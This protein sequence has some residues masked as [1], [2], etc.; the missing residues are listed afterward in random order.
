[1]L[2]EPVGPGT[3][4]SHWRLPFDP[5]VRD[6]LR[7]PIGER[8]HI[9]AHAVRPNCGGATLDQLDAAA[10][11]RP[12]HLDHAV[13]L[14]LDVADDASLGRGEASAALN[15]EYAL[16]IGALE[17]ARRVRRNEEVVDRVGA[18]RATARPFLSACR[19]PR[20]RFR[21]GRCRGQ[22]WSVVRS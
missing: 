22:P 14:G 9:T 12:G 21:P 15:L 11:G 2:P 13:A 17:R 3:F 4:S 18:E 7:A 8:L 20:Q 16:D 5:V 1:M 10:D 19:G 6:D